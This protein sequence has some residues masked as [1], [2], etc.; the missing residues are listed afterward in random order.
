MYQLVNISSSA[1][2]IEDNFWEMNPQ[3]KYIEPFSAVYSSDKSKDK[4][5]SSKTMWSVWMFADPSYDNKIYRLPHDAKLRAI[6]KFNPKFDPDA[7]DMVSLIDAYR[8][9]CMTH[10]ARAFHEEEQLLAKRA[11]FLASAE[12]TFDSYIIDKGKRVLVKGTATDIDKMKTMTLR[13]YQ[14]YA[15]VR[16]MFEFENKQSRVFGG[17]SETIREKGGLL[18]DVSEENGND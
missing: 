7:A 6:K 16:K 2:A 13:I 14:Q 1:T 12:Y 8:N 15:E 17:R 4:I 18:L 3:L 11:K 9:T 5:N 10:A